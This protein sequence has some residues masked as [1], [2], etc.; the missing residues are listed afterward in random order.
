[1]AGERVFAVMIEPPLSVANGLLEATRRFF[2]GIDGPEGAVRFLPPERYAI[3]LVVAP[4]DPERSPDVVAMALRAGVADVAEFAVQLAPLAPV[5]GAPGVV[6]SAL[7]L[8]DADLGRVVA[9]LAAAFEARGL[10]GA[11]VPPP[12][13]PVALVAEG[14]AR[15]SCA[16]A[17]ADARDVPLA[18]WLVSALVAAEGNPDDAPGTWLLRRLRSQALRRLGAR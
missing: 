18:G 15:E 7:R 4:V 17:A 11:V 8:Q 1:M 2:A 3:P 5:E 6:G 9:A 10:E 12:V 14:A 16:V 13:L